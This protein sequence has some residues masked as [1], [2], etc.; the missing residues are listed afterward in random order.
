ME[1]TL[2]K[3]TVGKSRTE[4]AVRETCQFAGDVGAK[5]QYAETGEALQASGAGGIGVDPPV[6]QRE[7][8]ELL[9]QTRQGENQV[10]AF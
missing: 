1:E 3:R 6:G 4:V 7:V 2:Q 5:R 9:F 8:D 10:D